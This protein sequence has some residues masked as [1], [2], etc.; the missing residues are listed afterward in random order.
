MEA[1]ALATCLGPTLLTPAEVAHQQ[2]KFINRT[3]EQ[4]SRSQTGSFESIG[5]LTTAYSWL[6]SPFL[7]LRRTTRTP[8][9]IMM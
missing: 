2:L 7:S 4:E 5:G 9:R 8:W 1:S 6:R 3:K